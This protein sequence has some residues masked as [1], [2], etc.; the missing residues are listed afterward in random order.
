MVLEWIPFTVCS[1][2]NQLYQAHAS[3]EVGFQWKFNFSLLQR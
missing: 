1:T 2:L 3:N